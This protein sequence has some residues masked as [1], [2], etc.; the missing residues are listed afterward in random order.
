M[1]SEPVTVNRT[2]VGVIGLGLLAIAGLLWALGLEGSQDMWRGACLKVGLVMGALWLALPSITRNQE[3]GRVSVGV[4]AGGLAVAILVARTK[5]SLNILVP[6]VLGFAF[7]LRVL[8]PSRPT[9]P[10]RPKVPTKD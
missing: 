1:K 10:S 3:L 2:L 5:I 6:A 8:G 4:L 9:R 7:L